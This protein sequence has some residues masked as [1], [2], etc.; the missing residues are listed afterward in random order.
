MA[1]RAGAERPRRV[2]DGEEEAHAEHRAGKGQAER[3]DENLAGEL[4]AEEQRQG[5]DHGASPQLPRVERLHRGAIR[6]SAAG[7]S[8]RHADLGEPG[9]SAG[10]TVGGAGLRV[11]SITRGP[12]RVD[13]GAAAP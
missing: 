1:S 9:L 12:R 4:A 2:S 13:S 5:V 10:R 3:S 11:A 7:S 6:A 8:V